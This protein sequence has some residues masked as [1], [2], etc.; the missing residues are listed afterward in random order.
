MKALLICPSERPGVAELAEAAPLSNIPLL[1]ATL[2]EYWLTYLAGNGCKH[3]RELAPVIFVGLHT[4]ISPKA[5]LHAPC[6]IGSNTLIEGGA[7]VGPNAIIEGGS[8]VEAGA[9]IRS[10]M[11]GLHTF[12]G[13]FSEIRESFVCGST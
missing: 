5:K 4:R 2:L 13:R 3:A 12:V 7:T 10:S 8:F 9:E 1:G 11:V 6:W